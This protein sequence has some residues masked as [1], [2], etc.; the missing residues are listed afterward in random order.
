MKKLPIITAIMLAC[1]LPM[2]GQGAL[3]VLPSLTDQIKGTAR[4]TSMA[5][6]FGALGGDITSIKQNPAGLGIYRTSEISI[7][8]GLNFYNNKITTPSEENKNNGFI[9]TGD[10]MGA[11]GTIKYR[12][13]SLRNLNFAFAYNNIARFEN[14][15]QCDW[16]GGVSFT[17]NIAKRTNQY[18]LTPS[19]LA[20]TSSN[21]PYNSAPWLSALAYNTNLIYPEN[22]SPLCKT[23]K[24]LQPFMTFTELY[25][26][27]LLNRTAGSIDEYDFN[28]SGNVLDIFYWGLTINL[29]NI[30]YR[31]ES[32]YEECLSEALINNNEGVYAPMEGKGNFEIQNSLKTQGYGLGAKIGFI[33]R[34]I[35]NIR[36]GFAIHSPTY[37]QLNDTYWAGVD[38]RFNMSNGTILSGN[39]DDSSL[40]NQ[41]DIGS[42]N[43]NYTS[44]WHILPSVAVVLGKSAIISLD[45]EYESASNVLYSSP[46]VDYSIENNNIKTHITDIHSIRIGGE[47]RITPM[48]S[49]RCGY[50]LQSTPIKAEL[51]NDD[52]FPEIVEGTLTTYTLPHDIHNISCGLGYRIN[53]IFIDAAYTHRMQKFDVFPY[54]HS[55]NKSAQMDMHHNMVKLT[56]GYKF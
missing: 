41:T 50:A 27:S 20:S 5:G 32:Y 23:Y 49:V 10:N 16:R 35:T 29:T 14:A 37:Y 8:L 48:F 36:I 4:F 38:Y 22:K 11:V 44:P 43:Y 54:T 28:I 42:F 17:E 13:G 1:A 34:P 46:Y 33:F 47:Y 26:S 3:D 9:F 2:W 25:S 39:K 45:Y 19:D 6:A 55:G 18:N 53:N 30:D 56:F 7:T 15:Y 12:S 51:F 40:R 24:G 31:I 21:N 52:I